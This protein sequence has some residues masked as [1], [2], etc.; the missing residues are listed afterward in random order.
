[1]PPSAF[2][3]P[4]NAP[5]SLAAGAWPQTRLGELTALPRDPLAGLR[6]PTSKRRGR[7]RRGEGRY[8]L[9]LLETGAPGSV[10]KVQSEVRK[11]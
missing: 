8:T 2:L 3:Y 7:E 6:G 4:K 5:K 1:M 9:T 10:V 11:L